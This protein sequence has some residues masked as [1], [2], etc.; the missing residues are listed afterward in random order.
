LNGDVERFIKV[1]RTK[2]DAT[3][4]KRVILLVAA[5]AMVC[6]PAASAAKTDTRVTLDPHIEVTPYGSIWTGEIFSSK[7]AC[8]N[9]RRVLVYRVRS[10]QDDK[11]GSTLS[12]KGIAS[13]GYYWGYDEDGIAPPGK[14][15]VKVLP[16][17]G[18]N[19]DRSNVYNFTR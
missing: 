12:H 3:V 4:K 13:P 8:K 16:T 19:G 14:Y 6:V 1:S 7:K 18:C 2:G 10:G 17:N 9:E 15:Y 11:R 5:V